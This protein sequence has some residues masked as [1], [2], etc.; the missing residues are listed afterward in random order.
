MAAKRSKLK[1]LLRGLIYLSIWVAIVWVVSILAGASR[2]HYAALTVSS[3]RVVIEDSTARGN[4]ISTERAEQ[5]LNSSG[6]LKSGMAIDKVSL[7]TIEY[8]IER[9]GFVKRAEAIYNY[10]GD[11]AVHI[12]QRQAVARIMLDGYNNYISEDGYIFRK[13]PSS[14]LYTPVVTGSYRPLV[15]ASFVGDVRGYLDVELA[16][17]DKRIK[18]VE[19]ER[20]PLYDRE[21]SNNEDKRLLRRRYINK[22]IF[23]SRDAFERRVMELREDNRVKREL[24]A[25]RQRV[26]TGEFEAIDRRIESLRR[27]QFFLRKK[28]QDIHNLIIFVNMIENDPFWSGEVTQIE[29]TTEDD[30]RMKISLSVR[31][32]RFRVH[33]GC[34]MPEVHYNPELRGGD[35]P[36]NRVEQREFDKRVK[37]NVEMKLSRLRRFYDE[38]LPRMGW[39]RYKAINL[40]FENQVVC[41]KL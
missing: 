21:D 34:I 2:S 9:N 7:D 15:P 1:G 36:L 3:V 16:K 30:G 35:L 33:L 4:L 11:V 14:S 27:E 13:P 26:L 38:A 39:D 18:D 5:L 6:L 40:E 17:I 8:I 24:Y 12:W 37:V 25:Y 41:T 10:E 19:R 22:T 20:L 28:Y 31:S 29:L 23:E 32:G